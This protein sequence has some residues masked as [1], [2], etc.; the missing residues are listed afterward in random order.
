MLE[1]E[2]TAIS[3]VIEQVVTIGGPQRLTPLEYEGGGAR[4]P[5]AV[6]LA[7]A[8]AY[9]GEP[10]PDLRPLAGL[11]PAQIRAT[12]AEGMSKVRTTIRPAMEEASSGG[13]KGTA[14]AIFM[15]DRWYLDQFL[16]Q[17]QL[18]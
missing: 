15:G 9:L 7:E 8:A 5:H 10:T 3:A 12:S 1:L 6:V 13:L 11:M 16:W 14:P 4:P 2:E 17:F 18:Y